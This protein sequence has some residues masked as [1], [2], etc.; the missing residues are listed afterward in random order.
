V[1][2]VFINR[3]RRAMVDKRRVAAWHWETVRAGDLGALRALAARA[4]LSN[5]VVRLKVEMKLPAPEYEEAEALLEELA[6][7]PAKHGR[8]GVLQL[9]REG[10]QLDVANLAPELESL[11]A[12]LQAAARRLQAAAADPD[13][14]QAAERALFH[15]FRTARGA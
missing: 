6:G 8:A 3:Q 4:D 1:A 12:V 10:L 5:R 13:T 7:T 15:L 9:E 11:P 14:R 2:L